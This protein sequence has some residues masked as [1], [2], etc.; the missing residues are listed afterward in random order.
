MADA[1]RKIA[2]AAVAGRDAWPCR[3]AVAIK[4]DRA[5]DE[6]ATGSIASSDSPRTLKAM[7]SPA[8]CRNSGS[9][10]S[11]ASTAVSR[12]GQ[13]SAFASSHIPIA[14]APACCCRIVRSGRTGFSCANSRVTWARH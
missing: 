4:L 2:P 6:I 3:D 10:L 7:T 9:I 11:I 1:E 13:V 14:L 5:S 12:A 8:S